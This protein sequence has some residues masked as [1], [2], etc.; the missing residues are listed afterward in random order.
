MSANM[1]KYLR[2]RLDEQNERLGMLWN[3]FEEDSIT[4]TPKVDKNITHTHTDT[5]FW[6]RSLINIIAKYSKK[7]NSEFNQC[8]YTGVKWVLSQDVGI[9]QCHNQSM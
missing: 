7:L 5:Q 8:S 4:L 2:R 9:F 1:F 3:S 6:P